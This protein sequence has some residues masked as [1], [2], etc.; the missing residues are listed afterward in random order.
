MSAD[1]V[2]AASGDLNGTLRLWEVTTGRCLRTIAAHG[3]PV[4]AV[5]ISAGGD[6]IVSGSLDGTVRAWNTSPELREPYRLRVA[7]A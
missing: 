2:W 5:A 1:M 7:G 4:T 3:G 6:R